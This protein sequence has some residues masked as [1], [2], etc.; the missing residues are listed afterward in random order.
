[1]SSGDSFTSITGVLKLMGF[2]RH[3]FRHTQAL[4]F[5]FRK[6]SDGLCRFKALSWH[7]LPW[8]GFNPFCEEEDPSLKRFISPRFDFGGIAS[9]FYSLRQAVIFCTLKLIGRRRRREEEH[10]EAEGEEA[11]NTSDNVDSFPASFN[12]CFEWL[13]NYTRSLTKAP[14]VSMYNYLVIL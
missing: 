6:I 12:D 2:C 9:D 14:C 1:M 4:T 7:H 3:M 13:R 11:G 8:A 5:T 10:T